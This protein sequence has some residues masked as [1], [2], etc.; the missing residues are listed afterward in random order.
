M[1]H[2]PAC[3]A[4]HCSHLYITNPGSVS[5]FA[6]TW[7]S[8]QTTTYI[9]KSTKYFGIKLLLT[10]EQLLHAPTVQIWT[11]NSTILIPNN[12]LIVCHSSITNC[13]QKTFFRNGGTFPISGCYTST[14]TL[15]SESVLYEQ[16]VMEEWQTIRRWIGV[17]MVEFWAQIWTVGACR[18]SS[19]VSSNN[20][21][22]YLVLLL[23]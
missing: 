9:S 17:K 20:I 11:W 5:H 10:W 18:T 23:M 6:K 22:K 3:I 2:G 8:L 12:L 1:N 19:Q 15:N 7:V 14:L 16:F 13:S 21:S 4:F